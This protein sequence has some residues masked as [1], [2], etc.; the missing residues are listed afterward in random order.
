MSPET[1]R[2]AVQE[3]PCHL[4]RKERKLGAQHILV[5]LNDTEDLTLVIFNSSV[6][7]FHL[8]G[9]LGRGAVIS[10]RNLILHLKER[11][12]G[13]QFTVVLACLDRNDVEPR[14]IK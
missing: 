12:R 7:L 3:F 2:C 1:C 5:V 13:D 10:C 9:L 8:K 11:A 6:Y 4:G 14:K